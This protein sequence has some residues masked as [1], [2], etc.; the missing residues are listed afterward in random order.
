VPIGI[1]ATRRPPSFTIGPERFA[2]CWLN[3]QASDSH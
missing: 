2:R 3:D 1:C